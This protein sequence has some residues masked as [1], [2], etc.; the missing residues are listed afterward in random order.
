MS[1]AH[2]GPAEGRARS[3]ALADDRQAIALGM[4]GQQEA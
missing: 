4:T 3:K 2:P 1:P